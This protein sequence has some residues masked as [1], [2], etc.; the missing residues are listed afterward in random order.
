MSKKILILDDEA[1]ILNA[2]K[3][4]LERAGYVVTAVGDGQEGINA[5]KTEQFDLIVTD[6]VMPVMDGFKFFKEVK[7]LPG[8]AKVPV[9]VMTAHASMEDSFRVFDVAEFFAKPVELETVLKTIERLLNPSFKLMER[10]NIIV[11]GSNHEVIGSMVQLLNDHGQ[12][13]TAAHDEIEFLVNALNN[14][15]DMVLIDVLLPKLMAHEVIGALRAFS[16]FSRLKILAYTHFTEKE[17]TNVDAVEQLKMGKNKCIEAGA[18]AYIG[19][20][21]K[22]TFIETM[23]EY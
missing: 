19:R 9:I 15:P 14:P 2:F 8:Y 5:A 7:R 11:C 21:S 6:V 1:D 23:R 10:R 4:N 17:L 12:K 22:V 3:R 20:F 18:T 13:A 16:R